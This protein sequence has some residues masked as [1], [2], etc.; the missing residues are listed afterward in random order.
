MKYNTFRRLP[1]NIGK[2]KLSSFGYLIPKLSQIVYN[3]YLDTPKDE[4]SS[5]SKIDDFADCHKVKC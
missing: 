4:Q 3:N 5:K 2:S 1:S